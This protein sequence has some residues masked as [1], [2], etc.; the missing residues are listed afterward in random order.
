MLDPSASAE[1]QK[2][3]NESGQPQK[4]EDGKVKEIDVCKFFKSLK[5]QVSNE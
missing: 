1:G 2:S 5:I 4:L 3:E